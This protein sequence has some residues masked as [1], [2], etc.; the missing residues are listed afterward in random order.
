MMFAVDYPYESSDTAGRF[1]D[2]AA[3]PEDTRALIGRANAR[4]LL[5]LAPG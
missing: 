1:L 5:K 4:A 3:I 2:T